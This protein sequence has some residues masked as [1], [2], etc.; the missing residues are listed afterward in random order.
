MQ[1]PAGV[2]SGNPDPVPPLLSTGIRTLFAGS[3]AV[4]VDF[5]VG[6]ASN[7]AF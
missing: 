5:D 4:H 3:A 6:P 7:K 1:N 2:E